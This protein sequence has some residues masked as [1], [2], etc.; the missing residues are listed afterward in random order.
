MILFLMMLFPATALARSCDPW[1]M[2]V[3]YPQ[4]RTVVIFVHHNPP[5]KTIRRMPDPPE[6]MP[7]WGRIPGPN[8]KRFVNGSARK[9]KVDQYE[10]WK[11]SRGGDAKP[12]DSGDRRKRVEEIRRTREFIM[13][14]L[15]R[16]EDE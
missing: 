7:G 14:A 13:D 10:K 5:V 1:Q 3:V 2:R 16:E 8:E 12:D 11:A 9:P 15:S 6:P 4:T